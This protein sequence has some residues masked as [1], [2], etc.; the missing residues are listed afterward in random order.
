VLFTTMETQKGTYENGKEYYEEGELDIEAELINA[1]SE[2][3][4]ERKKTES[5]KEEL[6]KLKES[7]QNSKEV[8]HLKIK[9][10][11]EEKRENILTSYL[12]EISKDLN[13]IEAKLFP[14][15]IRLEE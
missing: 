10:K 11:E 12:K 9:V 8:S 2:I 6:I 13:K 14:Q 3:K 15:E 5:F 4:R 1:L 7:S